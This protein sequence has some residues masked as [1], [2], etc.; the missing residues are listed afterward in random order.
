MVLSVMLT[1]ARSL[2]RVEAR[3]SRYPEN[4]VDPNKLQRI[5]DVLV[6]LPEDFRKSSGRDSVETLG[7]ILDEHRG[8]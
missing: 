2:T 6:E 8:V 3:Q 1:H 7:K 4:S 5:S